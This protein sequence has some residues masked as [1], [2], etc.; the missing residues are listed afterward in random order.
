MVDP[1]RLRNSLARFCESFVN[2]EGEQ[3]QVDSQ[4]CLAL[5]L[6]FMREDLS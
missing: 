5:L 2:W 1:R 4:E 6:K 3:E